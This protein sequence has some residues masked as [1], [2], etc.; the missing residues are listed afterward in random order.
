MGIFEE[1][2]VDCVKELLRPAERV[3]KEGLDIVVED[4]PTREKLWLRVTENYDRYLDGECG[5][6]LKDLDLHFRGKFEAA[7]AILAW[8]F[9]QTGDLYPPAENRYSEREIEAVEK[10]LRYNVFEVYSRDDVI[11][12]IMHR[13]SDVLTLL[14]DYYSGVDAWVDEILNDPSVKL[15]LRHF[16]K[17]KWDSYKGKINAAVAEA[18]VR[19]DWFRDFLTLTEE[20]TQA[21]ERVYRKKLERKEREAEALRERIEEMLRNI[22][23]EKEML[24]KRLEATERVE[25]PKLTKDKEEII[26]QFNEEKRKLGEEIVQFGDEKVRKSLEDELRRAEEE[27]SRTLKQLEE[28]LRRKETELRLR[29]E[30]VKRK[31]DEVS[32]KIAEFMRLSGKIER[33]SRFVR[34]DEARI[35]EMNFIGRLKSKIREQITVMGKKFKVESLREVPTF[36]KSKFR[37]KL[38]E[39]DLKNVPDNMMLEVRLRERK[40]LGR[41]EGLLVKAVFC[42]RPE[43]YAEVGFDTDPLELADVNALLIDAR[44]GG[45]GRTV[46]LVASPTG[47]EKRIRDYISSPDFHKNFISENVSLLLLDLESGELLYNPHDEYAKAFAPLLRLEKDNELTAKI[48]EAIERLLLVKGYVR[49]EDIAAEFPEDKVKR[50]FRKLA[51]K[52]GYSTKYI[53]G[54]GYVLVREG[55]V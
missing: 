1:G 51:R 6:F 14:R 17:T 13:D 42:S 45:A 35:M 29:E 28:E 44:N 15:P 16:L 53:E 30:E 48:E 2:S 43:R 21:V 11:K 3:L 24:V 33:G 39:R 4:F 8:S 40:L 52:P 5:S 38:S 31:E 55:F 27:V 12:R 46:L 25:I 49:L 18:T 50:A 37:G 10:V 9:K 26:R 36:D 34:V 32:R 19:F 54:V 22:E 20:E 23:E 41:G 47:F 7:L